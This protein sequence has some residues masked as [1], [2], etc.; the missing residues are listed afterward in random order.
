MYMMSSARSFLST[1]KQSQQGSYMIDNVLS[2]GLTDVQI[3]HVLRDKYPCHRPR[4]IPTRA[5]SARINLYK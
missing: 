1:A 4:T 5:R 3:L 2:N